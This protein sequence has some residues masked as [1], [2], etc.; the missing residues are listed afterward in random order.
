MG[1]GR[2]GDESNRSRSERMIRHLDEAS[3]GYWLAEL[4]HE[5]GWH[6]LICIL[7]L[8]SEHFRDIRLGRRTT[9]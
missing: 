5:V 9:S 8:A 1:I 4:E 2:C 3:M 7:S 6:L